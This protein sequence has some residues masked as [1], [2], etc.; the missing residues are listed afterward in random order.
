MTWRSGGYLLTTPPLRLHDRP[1]GAESAV[2]S[3]TIPIITVAPTYVYFIHKKQ[4]FKYL[5]FWAH[6]VGP[7]GSTP[8]FSNPSPNDTHLR[9]F[10]RLSTAIL[11]KDFTQTLQTSSVTP[12]TTQ[13]SD[14]PRRLTY[15]RIFSR[16]STSILT[17][18]TKHF[19]QAL[20][21][22]N[23][24]PTPTPLS[25][26]T[27]RLTYPSIF[28]RLSTSILTILT[29]EFTQALPTSSPVRQHNVRIPLVALR[30][31]GFFHASLPPF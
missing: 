21:T 9:I 30:T 22:S 8:T 18:L 25:D 20:P 31:R 12:T 5:F 26:S 6:S 17:I 19:T 15:P 4:S 14:L 23:V 3:W 28:F 13:H 27:R 10:R 7:R 2:L 1:D 11:T 29:N 24:T 16:L